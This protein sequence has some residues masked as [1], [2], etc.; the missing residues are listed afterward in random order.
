MFVANEVSIFHSRRTYSELPESV[1]ENVFLC[2]TFYFF[3]DL[4]IILVHEQNDNF[5]SNGRFIDVKAFFSNV[6]KRPFFFHFLCSPI[7]PISV[8]LLNLSNR[9]ELNWFERSAISSIC[10]SLFSR[11]TPVLQTSES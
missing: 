9:L 3:S 4:T 5:R 11:L 8:M 6:F 2:H 1:G 7:Y 10:G